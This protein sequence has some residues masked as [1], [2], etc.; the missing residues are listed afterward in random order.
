MD[1]GFRDPATRSGTI[2]G[3][4]ADT[5]ER[6]RRLRAGWGL[7][8]SS[9]LSWPSGVSGAASVLLRDAVRTPVLG[10]DIVRDE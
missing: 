8:G 10:D 4:S 5:A 2:P 1:S 3:A 9:R 6:A 7:S